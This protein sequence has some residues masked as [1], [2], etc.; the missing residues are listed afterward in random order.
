MSANIKIDIVGGGIGG[1]TLGAALHRLGIEFRI[2]EQS[3]ALTA[4]G[5]GLTLQRNAL[6]AL[7]TI[8]FRTSIAARG[9]AIRN[10]SLRTPAG[11]V[12][13]T[14]T[15]ELCALHRA[16]LLSALA[17][18]VPSSCLFLGHRVESQTSA[19]FVVA[20][21]GLHSV[22][23]RRVAPD[24]GPLREGGYTAWRGLAPRAAA[25]E[26][27]WDANAVAETWGRGTRF[28]IV[29]VDGER[30]Y[31]FAV[32]PVEP[33]GSQAGSKAFLLA[34]FEGWHAPIPSLID[35]TP[36]ETILESKIVDRAP[37]PHWHSENLFLLG[38]AAHP[39]TPNLGQGG[40]QAVEDAIVL[41]H[42]FRAL[43][44]GRL[45][46]AEIGARYEQHRMARAYDIVERSFKFGRLARI[47]NPLLVG[48]RNVAFRLTPK[49]AQ[50]R[51]LA[52]ILN[53]PG[54][55]PSASLQSTP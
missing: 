48:L 18:R 9:V 54:V 30:I 46:A 38:D 19:D 17:E 11:K 32:A 2:L 47:S 20:A 31:W 27:V 43:R 33:L 34:T 42:L 15:L 10:G 21:D 39:M 52:R 29:P 41:A 45:A 25:P 37:I 4:V 6:Q 28:G 13:T 51:Q 49:R 53:F 3:P 12:L 26:Q 44:D 40:C 50:E 8:D 22:F 16:T 24:E 14:M 1:V 55:P 7:E 23:R 35:A 36:A 5:Y